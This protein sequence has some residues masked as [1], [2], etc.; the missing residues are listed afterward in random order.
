MADVRFVVA[1]VP[2]SAAAMAERQAVLCRV[3]GK[4]EF[5]IDA[6]VEAAAKAVLRRWRTRLAQLREAGW[7]PIQGLKFQY[8]RNCPPAGVVARP[9]DG[10]RS[11]V[12]PCGLTGVCPWC[13]SR[14]RVLAT[15]DRVWE[16]LLATGDARAGEVPA[17][18]P[19]R[20]LVRVVTGVS[21]ARLPGEAMAAASYRIDK[22]VRT[23]RGLLV[24]GY[25]LVTVQPRPSGGWSWS[26]RSL[27]LA[28]AGYESTPGSVEVARPTRRTVAA[29]VAKFARYPLGM[30]TADPGRTAE[31]LDARGPFRMYRAF[32][33]F[34]RNSAIGRGGDG[35]AEDDGPAES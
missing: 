14:D 12:R 19:N 1:S 11:S 32:G 28:P 3:S 16:V 4:R 25:L 34:S 5:Q 15:F 35:R 30:M 21:S 23:R 24:G 2:R 18:R 27:V 9:A 33:A 7:G 10:E 22:T 29:A 31:V 6:A 17:E 20:L 13:W 8:A 26:I